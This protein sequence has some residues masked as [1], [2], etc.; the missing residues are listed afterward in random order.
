MSERR[1]VVEVMVFIV[2]YVAVLGSLTIFSA[3]VLNK[4]KFS[5]V[6]FETKQITNQTGDNYGGD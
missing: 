2:A 5:G 3:N 6:H 4:M 1:R